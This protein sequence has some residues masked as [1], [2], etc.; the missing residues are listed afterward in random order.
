MRL[1]VNFSTTLLLLIHSIRTQDNTKF[2]GAFLDKQ[3]FI[4]L[5]EIFYR[6]AIR[7]KTMVVS[8]LA[9]T[10]VPKYDLVYKNI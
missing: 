2:I 7:G 5:V 10:H 8:P 6:G 9:Q 1:W 4:D 3:D